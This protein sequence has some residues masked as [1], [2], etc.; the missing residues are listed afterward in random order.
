M[1]H[2]SNLRRLETTAH[3]DEKTDEFVIN[4]PTLTATKCVAGVF[5]RH[6]HHCGCCQ[7]QPSD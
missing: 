7:A 4:T 3:F 5:M 6:H 1:G 2:G